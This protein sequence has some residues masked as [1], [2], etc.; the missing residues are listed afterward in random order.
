MPGHGEKRAADGVEEI[1]AFHLRDGRLVLGAFD[2][3]EI[4]Q[5]TQHVFQSSQMA[6]ND[7]HALFGLGGIVAPGFAQGLKGDLDRGNRR[8]QLVA[9]VGDEIGFHLNRPRQRAHVAQYHQRA[10]IGRARGDGLAGELLAAAQETDFT[11]N[12]SG[13]GFGKIG[14]GLEELN[15]RLV[16]D[17]AHHFLADGLLRG[18]AQ[19]SARGGVHEDQAVL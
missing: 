18:E 14:D 10:A 11:L 3:R 2:A 8:A 16:G 9:G 5:V 15:H 17:D 6:V 12:R 1:G 13:G 4:E 7:D 19:Q